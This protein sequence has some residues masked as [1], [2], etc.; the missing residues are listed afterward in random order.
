VVAW[1]VKFSAICLILAA[2]SGAHA[3]DAT[4]SP[5]PMLTPLQKHVTLQC[6]TEPPFQNPFWNNHRPGIYVCVISGEPLFSSTDK[7]DSGTG[8]PSFTRPIEKAVVEEKVDPSHGMDRTEV[9]SV[10][11]AS[12]LGHVFPDGPAP[13]G[14]RY[15]INSA[16]LRFIPA[17][18]LEKEGYGRFRSLFPKAEKE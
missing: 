13:T 12:H 3:A 2:M 10:R 9:R 15:C 4:P 17:E 1:L 16:S 8:W 14:Q 7:F 11:G 5:T 18:D 6:G